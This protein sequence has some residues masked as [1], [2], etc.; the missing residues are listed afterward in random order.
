M[1][2]TS[3]LRHAKW[4]VRSSRVVVILVPAF[5]MISCYQQEEN[6]KCVVCKSSP[7]L[8]AFA[9]NPSRKNR[10]LWPR[11][12]ECCV[13]RS[14]NKYKDLRGFH[15]NKEDCITCSQLGS[16]L[17]CEVCDQT[18]RADN[19]ADRGG[20]HFD[21]RSTFHKVCLAC[22]DLGYSF[23]DVKNYRCYGCGIKGHK[24]F[25]SH[26]LTHKKNAEESYYVLNVRAEPA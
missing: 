26:Q 21:R 14:C 7:R 9:R 2:K 12:K 18:K 13:C 6:I 5:A 22:E 20:R 24:K 10:V 8:T 15:R 4:P 23:R 1:K 11:C 16:S 3:A 25:L 17:H 19:F